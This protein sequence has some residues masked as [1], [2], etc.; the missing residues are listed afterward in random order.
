MHSVDPSYL[1]KQTA[2]QNSD[3]IVFGLMTLFMTAGLEVGPG[4]A[5]PPKQKECSELKKDLRSCK[6][7]KAVD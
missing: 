7:L 5:T 1:Q 6:S 4:A 2:D 3:C